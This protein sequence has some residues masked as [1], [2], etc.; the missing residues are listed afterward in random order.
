MATRSHS[1]FR[2]V[3]VMRCEQDRAALAFQ[4]ADNVPQLAARL[5]VESG[6]RFVEE[7]EF[8]IADQGAGDG[9]ALALASRQFC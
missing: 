4:L 2:F 1:F 9:Q 7:Q 8:G 3:H 6:G 5:R